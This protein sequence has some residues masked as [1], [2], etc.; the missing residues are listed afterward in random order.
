AVRV[1]P[2]YTDD[3]V[4]AVSLHELGHAL[5]LGHTDVSEDLMYPIL[6][7]WALRGMVLSTLD[8]YG[9]AQIFAWLP[10]GSTDNFTVPKV[11]TLPSNIPYEGV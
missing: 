11:I 8:L 7:R 6:M 10:S 9:V 4:Y 5:G 1:G 2:R 3:I